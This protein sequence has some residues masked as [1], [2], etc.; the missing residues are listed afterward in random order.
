MATFK[1]SANREWTVIID[2]AV[3]VRARTHGGLNIGEVMAAAQKVAPGQP[4]EVDPALLLDLCYYGCE[5]NSRI[6]AGKVD[7]NEFLR[8]LKGQPM[9]DAISAAAEA[10]SECFSP[11]EDTD[12]ADPTEAGA[13]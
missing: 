13:E 12:S 2:G 11:G 3:L 7:K 5:R 6:V 4:A 8:S 1:D 10:L 9:I